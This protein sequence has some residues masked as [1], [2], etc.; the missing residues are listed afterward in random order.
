MGY[1]SVQ[2][3]PGLWTHG[4]VVSPDAVVEPGTRAYFHFCQMEL[5]WGYRAAHPRCG[6]AEDPNRSGS[7]G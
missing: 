1:P 6:R 7:A 2:G 4:R 5:R 3:K